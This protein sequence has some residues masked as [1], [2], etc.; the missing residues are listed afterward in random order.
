MAR[1]RSQSPDVAG[2]RAEV[3]SKAFWEG[4]MGARRGREY[5]PSVS[6]AF[7]RRWAVKGNSWRGTWDLEKPFKSRIVRNRTYFRMEVN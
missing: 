7:S 2:Y 4:R 1:K 3:E 6:R 5:K